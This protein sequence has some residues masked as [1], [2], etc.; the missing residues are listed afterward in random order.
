M[1][2]PLKLNKQDG[3]KIVKGLG[4]AFAG[5]ALTYLAEVIPGINFGK[6]TPVIVAVNSVIVNVVRKLITKTDEE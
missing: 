6:W 4:I 2:E 1:S 3:I 5:T